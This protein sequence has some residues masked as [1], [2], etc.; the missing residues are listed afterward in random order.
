[1]T[2]IT[3]EPDISYTREDVAKYIK[4]AKLEVVKE[5]FYKLDCLAAQSEEDDSYLLRLE[6]VK[7][8]R[9]KYL[10]ELSE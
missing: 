6:D 2:D 10:G 5:I 7:E 9:K 8:L 4:Q 1:M 3:G